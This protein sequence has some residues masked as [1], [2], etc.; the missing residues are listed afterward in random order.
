MFIVLILLNA[1]TFNSLTLILKIHISD[2]LS[3][4][5]RAASGL[6]GIGDACSGIQFGKHGVW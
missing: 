2:I 1:F 4:P 5:S 6:A 3:H